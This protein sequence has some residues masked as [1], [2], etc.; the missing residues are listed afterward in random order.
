MI[1]PMKF[2]TAEEV[3]DADLTIDERDAV[4][5]ARPDL[6]DSERE[7]A[8]VDDYITDEDFKNGYPGVQHLVDALY[9]K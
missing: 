3:M 1:D 7:Y 8:D 2:K 5:E 9:G 6:F 4:V